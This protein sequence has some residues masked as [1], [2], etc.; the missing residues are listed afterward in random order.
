MPSVR[1]RGAFGRRARSIRGAGART[2]PSV[3]ARWSSAAPLI[4]FKADEKPRKRDTLPED[5]VCSLNDP[6]LGEESEV[7][8]N[9]VCG[10]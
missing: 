3:A 8:A 2:C 4:V 9:E 6:S 7:L 5:G 1:P 10:P